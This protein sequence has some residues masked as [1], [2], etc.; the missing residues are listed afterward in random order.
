MGSCNKYWRDS[1]WR[2]SDVGTIWLRRGIW[3]QWI[4]HRSYGH[5]VCSRSWPSSAVG[6]HHSRGHR[7]IQGMQG[8]CYCTTSGT[9][10]SLVRVPVGHPPFQIDVE[11]L[12]NVSFVFAA[13]N[14]FCNCLTCYSL[15]PRSWHFQEATLSIYCMVFTVD[16]RIFQSV[17]HLVESKHYNSD[18]T[19]IVGS[20]TKWF[21]Y[22]EWFESVT[23]SNWYWC[24]HDQLRY[25]FI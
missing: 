20:L 22:W 4:K 9:G 2:C 21:S 13:D 1:S 23:S 5:R 10:S 14:L 3:V 15:F 8:L 24:P 16:K 11:D 17:R 18:T 19:G 12:V 7:Q 6:A 25:I